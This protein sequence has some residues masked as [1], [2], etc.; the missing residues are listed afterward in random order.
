MSPQPHRAGLQ[1]GIFGRRKVGKSSL[2]SALTRQASLAPAQTATTAEP[3]EVPIELS[4]L[5]PV[6]F[7]D[8]A[9]ID[10]VSA[11]GAQRVEHTMKT[12][13]RTELAI[14]VLAEEGLGSLE[15][16]LLDAF[17]ARKVPVLPV[18]AK[19]DLAR[20]SDSTLDRLE[21]RG[22]KPV[23]ANA[24]RGDGI[25]AV[26]EALVDLAPDGYLNSPTILS[27]LVPPGEVGVL[28][29]PIDREASKGRLSLPRSQAIRDLVDHHAC[30]L[31][32]DDR[33]LAGALARLKDKPALVVCDSEVFAKVSADTPPDVPITSFSI[34][35]ARQNGDLL[36]FVRGAMAIDALRPG[37]RIAMAEACS[38]HPI[39]EDVGRSRIPRWLGQYVGGA[40][41]VDQVQGRNFI[42]DP[43]QFKLVIHCGSCMLNRREVIGRIFACRRAG[44]PITNYGLALAYSLGIFE[45]ALQPFPTALDAYRQAV[46]ARGKS[47]MQPIS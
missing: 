11:L 10:D 34:L 9:G 31:V 25:D 28:V 1:I 32:V 22:L 27:D 6:V 37:D 39:G 12:L 3:L 29:V 42:D 40:L 14:L 17:E 16:S 30:A 36:Q 33:E 41:G 2:L 35:F 15:I 23:I 24:V 26:F 8:T 45:R 38:H 43:K 20:P 13:D 5:G 46:A 4:P 44:V 7:V 47:R 21:S 18:L 19:A